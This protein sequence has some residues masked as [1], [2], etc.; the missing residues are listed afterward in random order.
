M[1]H[2]IVLA[3]ML[4]VAVCVNAVAQKNELA[5]VAGVKITPSGS[6]GASTSNTVDVDKSFAFEASL[7]HTLASVPMVA[8]QLEIPVVAVPNSDISRSNLLAARSYSSIYFTPGFRLKFATALPVN[9][10]I[11]AGGG[12]ARFN[13]SSTNNAGG[14]SGATSTTKGAFD[15]GAG[16]D[17]KATGFPIALRV[18]AREFYA[19]V[20]NLALPSLDLH[21][22]VFFG[23]GIVFRF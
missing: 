22:N 5:L 14:P 12:M 21:H 1:I 11:S 15:V 9:P 17:F 19:G 18:E 4:F 2:K 6:F 23:G 13:P 10:W 3:S 20:P 16:I 8:L 7:A